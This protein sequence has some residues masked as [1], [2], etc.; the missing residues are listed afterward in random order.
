M[1]MPLSQLC[2]ISGVVAGWMARLGRYSPV[3]S[4]VETA[5]IV[6]QLF[7]IRH[8]MTE[9]GFAWLKAGAAKKAATAHIQ[10]SRPK[11]RTKKKQDLR[12]AFL[13]PRLNSPV[14]HWCS[15]KLPVPAAN[16]KVRLGDLPPKTQTAMPLF[17]GFGR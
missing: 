8:G 17:S 16:P 5:D 12:P 6:L 14:L 9:W 2:G 10:K 15:F 3:C 11:I 4:A 13:V 1:W 7:R